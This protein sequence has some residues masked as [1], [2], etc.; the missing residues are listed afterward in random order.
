MCR[1][2]VNDLCET[3]ELFGA[4]NGVILSQRKKTVCVMH[5]I[6]V[7][8]PWF[9]ESWLKKCSAKK[10]AERFPPIFTGPRQKASTQR[11]PFSEKKLVGKMVAGPGANYDSD[12]DIP[13]E[14]E[15]NMSM[16]NVIVVDNLPVS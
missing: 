14:K 2:H 11:P 16:D 10:R 4:R 3:C 6:R 13:F 15:L 1:Q 8:C 12:E 9:C 7:L 5:K